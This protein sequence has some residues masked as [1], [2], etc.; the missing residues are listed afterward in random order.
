MMFAD[1]TKIWKRVNSKQDSIGL[2]VDY[3]YAQSWTSKSLM[4]ENTAKCRIMHI[5]HKLETQY[6]MD[7]NGNKTELVTTIE[8][9]DLG[10]WITSDLKVRKQHSMTASKAISILNLIR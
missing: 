3:D 2:Q 5:G 4:G 1:D 6:F 10:V 7:D 8:Q 9:R